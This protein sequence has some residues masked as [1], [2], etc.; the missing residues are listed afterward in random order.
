MLS[1][2]PGVV[3]KCMCNCFTTLAAVLTEMTGENTSR[4]FNY[5]QFSLFIVAICPFVEVSCIFLLLFRYDCVRVRHVLCSVRLYVNS[6]L[7]T[8]VG[9][10]F[11]LNVHM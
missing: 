8:S 10:Q 2:S 6:T 3:N 11:S 4:L 5:S 1:L 7:N 9:R